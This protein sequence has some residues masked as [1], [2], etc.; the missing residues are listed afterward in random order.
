MLVL[1]M[2]KVPSPVKVCFIKSLEVLND[3]FTDAIVLKH[4]LKL[5]YK[6]FVE[7][8]SHL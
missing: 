3:P 5:E 8:F 1:L 6:H 4:L 2:I 7:I